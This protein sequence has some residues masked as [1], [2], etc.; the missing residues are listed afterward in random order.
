MK[1]LIIGFNEVPE[2]KPSPEGLNLILKKWNIKPSEAIFIGDMATDIQAGKAANVK[3][4]SKTC[5][6]FGPLNELI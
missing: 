1:E 3:T 2:V 5:F 4:V 6:Q